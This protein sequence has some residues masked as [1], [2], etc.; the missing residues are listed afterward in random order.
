M[1]TQVFFSVFN[2]KALDAREQAT[3]ARDAA[4]TCLKALPDV[5]KPENL[6]AEQFA[7]AKKQ[8]TYLLHYTTA[9]T[10]EFLKEFK[11]AVDEYKAALAVKSD[12][13]LTYYRLGLVYLQ[14]D[15]PRPSM[16]SGHSRGPSP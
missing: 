4:S 9:F 10:S 2:G 16:A 14:M 7:E 12:E 1:R 3:K 8:P 11:T 13:P 15:P 5:P 6:T